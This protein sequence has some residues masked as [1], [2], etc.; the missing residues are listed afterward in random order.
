MAEAP[1]LSLLTV[2]Q[3]PSKAASSQ[4]KWKLCAV[5]DDAATPVKVTVSPAE[6]VIIVFA[7]DCAMAPAPTMAE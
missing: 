7:P 4:A 2:G 1:S 6:S 5:N 3:F